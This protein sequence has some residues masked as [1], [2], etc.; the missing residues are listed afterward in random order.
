MNPNNNYPNDEDVDYI[1]GIDTSQGRN[2]PETPI[3]P[4]EQRKR[5]RKAQNVNRGH[6]RKGETREV[7]KQINVSCLEAISEQFTDLSLK[8]GKTKRT[9]LE[10]ALRH[11]IRRYSH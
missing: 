1:L 3:S 10:E 11:L 5:L 8:T 6:P 7:I 4:E 9:L 2:E